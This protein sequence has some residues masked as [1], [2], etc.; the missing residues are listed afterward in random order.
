MTFRQ[1]EYLDMISREGSISS[2]AKKLYISQSAL[3][4]QIC[5]MEKEYRVV[6][7]DRSHKPISLTENGQ[8]FLEA[9]QKILSIKNQL[10]HDISKNR[11]NNLHIK[12][13]PFY[14]T[15]LVP[16][17]LSQFYRQYPEI[18]VSLKSDWAPVLF[19]SVGHEPIDVYIHAFDLEPINPSIP[20]M[21]ELRHE[22]LFEEEIMMVIS[23]SHPLLQTL[24][25]Q[26]NA[27]GVPTVSIDEICKSKFI[28]PSTSSRLLDIVKEYFGNK[29]LPDQI[30]IMNQGFD[31]LIAQ[32]QY[33]D[34][35]T[36]LP[37]TAINFCGAAVGVRFFRVRERQILRP[38]VASYP[39]GNKLNCAAKHFIRI[40]REVMSS[41]LYGI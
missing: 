8:I 36:F 37:N 17:L 23:S 6:L 40:A 32:L 16:F 5:G 41:Q 4:Q 1:L 21:P 28:L 2:A 29:I 22:M 18:R 3:S 34:Y 39:V 7:L 12:T 19:R 15:K 14:G 20:L 26:N 10:E 38:V 31:A 27:S 11:D 24:S 35:L 13:V 9:A 30:Q 25:I 33:S